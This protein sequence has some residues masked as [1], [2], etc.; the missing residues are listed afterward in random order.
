M[1]IIDFFSGSIYDLIISP[2]SSIFIDDLRFVNLPF[3][4]ILASGWI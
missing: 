2:S 3:F 4:F 1:F